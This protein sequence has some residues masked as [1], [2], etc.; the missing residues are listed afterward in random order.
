[1]SWKVAIPLGCTLAAALAATLVAAEISSPL[2]RKPSILLRVAGGDLPTADLEAA[3]GSEA[4]RAEAARQEAAKI[5][6]QADA[7]K[8]ATALA[9][10]AGTALEQRIREKE[11]TEWIAAPSARAP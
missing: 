8:A 5:K 4:A 6:A 9:L 1:M 11:A 10:Q 7:L 3:Y 2:A